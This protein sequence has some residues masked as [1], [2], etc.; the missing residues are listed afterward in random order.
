MAATMNE[1][2]TD[3][4][5]YQEMLTEWRFAPAGS[6]IFRDVQ[7]MESL[8]ALKRKVGPDAAARITNFVG[9][10]NQ[11]KDDHE[12]WDDMA[13]WINGTGKCAGKAGQAARIR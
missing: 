4:A 6:P 5:I 10:A 7:F 3:E 11:L 2:P 13:E 12:F 9:H 1:K 8:A